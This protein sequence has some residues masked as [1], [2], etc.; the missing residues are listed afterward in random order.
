MGIDDRDLAE[1][2]RRGTEPGAGRVGCLSAEEVSEAAA[3]RDRAAREKAAAH[4]IEC[5]AC[6][7][8]LRL[9]LELEPWARRAGQAADAAS[10]P[11]ALPGWLPAAAALLL[12]LGAGLWL[13]SG[14]TAR[15]ADARRGPAETPAATSPAEGEVLPAAPAALSWAAIPGAK[16][17]SVELFDAESTLIWSSGRLPVPR[18]ELP[19]GIR[20]RLAAGGDFLW[21][22][23]AFEE[24]ERRDLPLARF[25][26]ASPEAHP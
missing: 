23:T 2:Y 15:D 18:V 14:K 9:A 3:G 17:Y 21:R 16:A 4:A 8:E 25:R 7:E 5:A 24:S 26:V 19:A 13:R 10:R 6:A 11:R 12:A 20:A 1:L 22:A